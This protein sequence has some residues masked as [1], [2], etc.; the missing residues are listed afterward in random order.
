MAS[1][2]E[3]AH[4][5]RAAIAAARLAIVVAVAANGTIGAA[6]TLPWRLPTDLRR[7]REV[8]TGHAVVMGRRTWTSI[9]RPLP[10]RQNLVV[11][12]S[13]T[14]RATGA[15]VVHSLDAALAA[16]RLPSPVFCIGGAELYA[17][18]LPRA[19][20]LLVT[21]IDQAFPGDTTFPA[22]DRSIWN[23]ICREPHGP[24]GPQGLS[25][26]FVTYRRATANADSGDNAS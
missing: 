4:A 9:G 16:A 8:T 11:S 20:V 17:A 5:S 24:D 3:Q 19:D 2:S 15:E 23:E 22:I 7:F 12:R 18:A 10:D 25:F 13:A 1:P 26:A 21:E 6:G 14:F